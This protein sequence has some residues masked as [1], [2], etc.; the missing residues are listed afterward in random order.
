VELCI[1]AGLVW[2]EELYFNS[3]K[4]QAN[5]AIDRLMPRVEWEARQHL[6]Q[7]FEV[8]ADTEETVTEGATSPTEGL[9]SAFA[10]DFR[11][12]TT[13]AQDNPADQKGQGLQMS[14]QI[15]LRL[16]GIELLQFCLYGTMDAAAVIHRCAP[17]LW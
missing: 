14:G 12:L 5:A 17:V 2:G 1:A 8:K 3:T 16:F 11:Q 9:P 7:L 6:Q 10:G 4:V 13:L 15:A